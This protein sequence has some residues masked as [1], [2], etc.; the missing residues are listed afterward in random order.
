M[1]RSCRESLPVCVQRVCVQVLDPGQLSSS[2]GVTTAAGQRK[3]LGYVLKWL[4]AK[5]VAALQE[6]PAALLLTATAQVPT[7]AV[8]AT[9]GSKKQQDTKLFQQSCAAAVAL[10]EYEVGTKAFSAPAQGEHG[11][12]GPTPE[13]AGICVQI[14]QLCLTSGNAAQA[15][16]HPLQLLCD[17]VKA[18]Q[19]YDGPELLHLGLALLQVLCKAVT[20]RPC[21]PNSRSS[22]C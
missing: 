21:M 11:A 1:V 14:M 9:L 5:L 16:G 19:G 7:T 8:T 13:A 20:G 17:L 6:T 2:R 22:T 12:S 15:S 18:L 4:V 10:A 3:W